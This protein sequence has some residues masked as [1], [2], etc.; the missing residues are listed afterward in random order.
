MFRE[1]F[2]EHSTYIGNR[3]G[4]IDNITPIQA[5]VLKND[6]NFHFKRYSSNV[7]PQIL[8]EKII[9]DLTINYSID[10]RTIYTAIVN[11]FPED[12]YKPIFVLDQYFIT[13]G[14]RA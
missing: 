5:P 14:I 10:A 3:R 1:I 6:I 11:I 2:L 13:F 4:K 7:I 12:N 8:A 9:D